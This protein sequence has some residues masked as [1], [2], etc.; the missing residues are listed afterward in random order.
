MTSFGGR[1]NEKNLMQRAQVNYL[2]IILSRSINRLRL[3]NEIFVTHGI[4][5]S[6]LL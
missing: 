4:T 3:L 5:N 6:L 1:F 2:N